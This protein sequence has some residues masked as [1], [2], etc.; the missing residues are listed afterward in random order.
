L[1]VSDSGKGIERSII[2]RIFEPYFTTKE[3]GK[4]TG[5]GLAVVHGIVK[6]HNGSIYVES[7]IGK[8]TKF[9]I[10][11][12]A[13]EITPIEEKSDQDYSLLGG[14]ENILLID[15]EENI[16]DVSTEILNKYGYNVIKCT[17]SQ[18]A[19]TVFSSDPDKFDLVITDMTMPGMLGTELSK[20]IKKI[21][22]DIPI[23]IC[24]GFSDI[25]DENNLS[26]YGIDNLLNK[27]I[28]TVDLL[29]AVR[30]A[31]DSKS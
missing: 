15:D 30:I 26:T 11:F 25:L 17:S 21:R 13:V 22:N 28:E 5:L 14:T 4:G 8:G 6:S 9:T 10:L 24:T 2:D 1:V 19:L 16:A 3:L 31:L 12:P 23:I 29:R 27:P 7:T 20:E 18:I